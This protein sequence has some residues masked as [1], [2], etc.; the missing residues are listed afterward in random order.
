MGKNGQKQKNP[1]HFWTIFN[2]ELEKFYSSV[3]ELAEHCQ[4]N[5][6]L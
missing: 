1:Q 4:L 5:N 2:R 3:A 6:D